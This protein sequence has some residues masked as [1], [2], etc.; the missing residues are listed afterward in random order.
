MSTEE[1]YCQRHSDLDKTLPAP[2]PFRLMT[3]SA[4]N[5]KVQIQ[6]ISLRACQVKLSPA[7]VGEHKKRISK[8]CAVY[9]FWKSDLKAFNIEKGSYGWSADDV[10][11]GSIPSEI[12]IV[13]CCGSAFNGN[14]A[15][16]PF[17]FKNYQL[18]FAEVM[19]DGV[20]IPSQAITLKY[21]KGDF[22]EAYWTLMCEEPRYGQCIEM[23]EYPDGY[24]VFRIFG[25]VG[26]DVVNQKKCGHTRINL[27]FAKA[28]PENA[29]VLLYASF[30]AEIKV[31]ATRNIL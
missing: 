9:P 22:S 28:L 17:N 13:L 21:T 11:H 8:H 1:I 3:E 12:K 23:K 29:T 20:P 2:L 16:N 4:D 14:Y 26:G 7:M 15:E 25:R 10:Y 24:Y 19:V 27:K 6:Y 30:P 31:D 5:Y 18:N